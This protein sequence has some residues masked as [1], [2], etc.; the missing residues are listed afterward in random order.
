MESREPP[1]AARHRFMWMGSEAE[2]NSRWQN[3]HGRM[4]GRPFM[5][6]PAAVDP[7]QSCWCSASAAC[8]ATAQR[9][10]F[11]GSKKAVPE[12]ARSAVRIN[13]HP[14]SNNGKWPSAW[15]KRLLKK[16]KKFSRRR[17]GERARAR[18]VRLVYASS[19]APAGHDGAI[20]NVRW[21]SASSR[22]GGSRPRSLVMVVFLKELKIVGMRVQGAKVNSLREERGDLGKEGKGELCTVQ[23]EQFGLPG[24]R[25][26]AMRVRGTQAVGHGC[27][28][29]H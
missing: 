20:T 2:P 22:A 23:Q 28:K 14:S 18:E 27:G 12:A 19:A 26:M 16:L 11:L 24:R 10:E 7:G 1:R 21:P 3:G 25:L 9:A 29:A 15:P 13:S 8:L 5:G 6:A 4:R 17:L